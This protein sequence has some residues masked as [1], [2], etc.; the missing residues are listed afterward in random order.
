MAKIVLSARIMVH[1]DS[2]GPVRGQTGAAHVGL[3]WLR[4]H[5]E[6]ALVLQL[7]LTVVG[8]EAGWGGCFPIIG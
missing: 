8:Y 3:G 6:I 1:N 2:P 4:F 7:G 5:T